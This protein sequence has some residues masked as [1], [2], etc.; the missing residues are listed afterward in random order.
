M[1]VTEIR[2]KQRISRVPSGCPSQDLICVQKIKNFFFGQKRHPDV[3]LA[4]AARCRTSGCSVE[5]A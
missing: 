1:T 4:D 3:G 2:G 5:I